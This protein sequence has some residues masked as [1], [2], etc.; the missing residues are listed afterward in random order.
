MKFDKPVI[1]LNLYVKCDK[2][3]SKDGSMCDTSIKGLIGKRLVMHNVKKIP[4]DKWI[5]ITLDTSETFTDLILKGSFAYDDINISYDSDLDSERSDNDNIG[6]AK[7]LEEVIE[8]ILEK[9]G[10]DE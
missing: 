6:L 1:V 9:K 8:D 2:S 3:A 10:E 4:I 7:I 5:K